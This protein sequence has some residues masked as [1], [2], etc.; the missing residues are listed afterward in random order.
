[1]LAQRDTGSIL[2]SVS[3]GQGA[4]LAGGVD[5]TVDSGRWV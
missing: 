2:D 3:H 1:L 4:V 5:V